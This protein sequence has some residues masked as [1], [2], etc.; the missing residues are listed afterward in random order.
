MEGSV[1]FWL[2]NGFGQITFLLEEYSFLKELPPHCK[3]IAPS[4]IGY[5]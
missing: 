3:L 2:P 4:P 1:F 5:S